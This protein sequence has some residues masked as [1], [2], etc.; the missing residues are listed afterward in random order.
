[1]KSSNSFENLVSEDSRVFVDSQ[2]VWFK[3]DDGLM[4]L[5]FQRR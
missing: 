1:M 3:E 2:H 5:K 4:Q